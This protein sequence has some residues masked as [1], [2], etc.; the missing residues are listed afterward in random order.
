M[1]LL[2]QIITWVSIIA[3]VGACVALTVIFAGKPVNA[4][5]NINGKSAYEIAV[6]NGFDGTETEWL[7][8][9]HGVDGINGGEVFGVRIAQLTNQTS[10]VIGTKRVIVLDKVRNYLPTDYYGKIR[11]VVSINTPTNFISGSTSLSNQFLFG[12]TNGTTSVSTFA[13]AG[14]S[15]RYGLEEAIAE[16]SY[17]NFEN[18]KVMC[19]IKSYSTLGVASTAASASSKNNISYPYMQRQTLDTTQKLCIIVGD[20]TSLDNGANWKV[21]IY[22]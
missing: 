10:V 9:L 11:V 20:D 13:G 5:T 16:L 18:M 4:N 7:A 15:L 14:I 21:E 22:K 1:K 3:V 8:S 19:E 6:D 17:A 12:Y 2:K